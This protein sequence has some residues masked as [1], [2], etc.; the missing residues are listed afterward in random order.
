MSLPL[1]LFLENITKRFDRK[2][3]LVY[4]WKRFLV[5]AFILQS[6]LVSRDVTDGVRTSP[7]IPGGTSA[8]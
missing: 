6:P 7:Y 1:P 2:Q 4:K 5:V 3:T 8:M